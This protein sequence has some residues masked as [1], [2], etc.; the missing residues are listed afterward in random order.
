MEDP[1]LR[2]LSCDIAFAEYAIAFGY[3]KA[4]QDPDMP[5]DDL[6]SEVRDTLNRVFA[7]AAA[8]YV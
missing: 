5:S 7:R 3:E 1:S 6:L 4:K 2:R 8:R